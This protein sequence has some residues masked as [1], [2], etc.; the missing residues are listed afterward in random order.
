MFVQQVIRASIDADSTKDLKE[1]HKPTFSYY[2]VFMQLECIVDL[3][4][5]YFDI[6]RFDLGVSFAFKEPICLKWDYFW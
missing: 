2:S 3:T 4:W 5:P 1:Q 6:E